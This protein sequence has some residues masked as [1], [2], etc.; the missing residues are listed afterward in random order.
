MNKGGRESEKELWQGKQKSE[1]PQAQGCGQPL[2]IGKGKET[3]STL[4]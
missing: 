4:P 3:V 2:E 1:G